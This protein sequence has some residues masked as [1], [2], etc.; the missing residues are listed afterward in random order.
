MKETNKLREA[1]ESIALKNKKKNCARLW[2][3][4]GGAAGGQVVRPLV[5][6]MAKDTHMVPSSY[7]VG[8]V[9]CGVV[10]CSV[11]W[12][13]VVWCGVMWCTVV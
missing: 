8:V 3:A 6:G 12:C 10:Y 9:W 2:L 11:V 1:S 7:W 4:P 5:M 13:N